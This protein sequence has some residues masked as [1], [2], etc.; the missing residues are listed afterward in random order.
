MVRL[1][2]LWSVGASKCSPRL[3]CPSEILIWKL[4]SAVETN[5]FKSSFWLPFTDVFGVLLLLKQNG[6]D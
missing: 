5:K 4:Q 1:R 2:I 3:I 6:F